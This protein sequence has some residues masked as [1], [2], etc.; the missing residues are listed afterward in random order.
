MNQ[1]RCLTLD[2][3]QPALAEVTYLL[4]MDHRVG[5]VQ[6]TASI[7]AATDIVRRESIDAVFVCLVHHSIDEAH[8]LTLSAN[9]HPKFVALA[10]DDAYAMSAFEMGAIDYIVKPI[11][12][13]ALDRAL[14]RLL[15]LTAEPA[16]TD[17]IVAE[18]SGATHFI[19]RRDILWIQA[20]GD[21][22]LLTTHQG[23]F[24]CRSSL[25]SLAERLL[26]F[27]FQRVHRQWLVPIAR[28]ETFSQS[29]GYASISIAG[30][31]IPVSRR[32]L[33]E[34][35]TRLTY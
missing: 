32:S 26:P 20:S 33:R 1:L 19:D 2:V 21:Y 3:D 15:N 17:R 10:R 14:T 29:D 11:T 25:T 23:D 31:D 7:E 34:L 6:A 13:S 28:I 35:K 8:R 9:T 4:D 27:G 5:R 22:T 12:R 24:T 30:Q 16:S 18:Q